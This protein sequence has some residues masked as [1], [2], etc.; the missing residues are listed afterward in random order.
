[1]ALHQARNWSAVR[2]PAEARLTAAFRTGQIGREEGGRVRD[3]NERSES[4]Q[5]SIK[6]MESACS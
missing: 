4:E 2:R 1:M 3:E 5:I 6:K